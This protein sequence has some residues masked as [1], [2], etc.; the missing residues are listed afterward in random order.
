MKAK[1]PGIELLPT[2]FTGIN[3]AK[4]QTVARAELLAHPEIKGISTNGGV[5]GQGTAA[6]IAALKKADSVQVVSYDTFP[7]EI[8]ALQ[9]GTLDGMICNPLSDMADLASSTSSSTSAATPDPFPRRRS[10]RT[11]RLRRPISTRP[12]PSAASARPKV[13]VRTL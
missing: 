1:Y 4:A 6:A 2:Q 10:C 11:R 7:P 5:V 13:C 9:A 12:T 3:S 8:K